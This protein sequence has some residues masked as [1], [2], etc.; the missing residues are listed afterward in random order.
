[1]IRLQ[2]RRASFDSMPNRLPPGYQ[3]EA[4]KQSEYT[5]PGSMN[6]HKSQPIGKCRQ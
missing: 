1:M 3:T 2:A 5:R 6:G 4:K